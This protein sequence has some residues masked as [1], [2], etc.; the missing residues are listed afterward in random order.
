MDMIVLM[1]KGLRD[2]SR[3]IGPAARNGR[4]AES[5]ARLSRIAK[6]PAARS[7][8]QGFQRRRAIGRRGTQGPPDYES[9]ALGHLL[10]FGMV[11]KRA[12]ADAVP[13]QHRSQRLWIDAKRARNIAGSKV[14]QRG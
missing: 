9:A 13:P 8:R 2:M 12:K 4:T 10:F 3:A 1:M 14:D 5:E 6:R 7:V 11:A